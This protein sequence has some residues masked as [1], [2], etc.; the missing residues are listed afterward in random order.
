M[1]STT[2]SS[3]SG[4][5]GFSGMLAILFIALKL[6]GY[7]NWPWLWVLSPIWIPLCIVLG[8]LAIAGIVFLIVYLRK[9]RPPKDQP[10]Q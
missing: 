5:I 6:T 8:I 7:I 3:A 9:Q 10:C 2:T 1:S 4:G